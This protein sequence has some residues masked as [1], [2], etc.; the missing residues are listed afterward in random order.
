MVRYETVRGLSAAA[1]TLRKKPAPGHSS[2][3]ARL[4]KGAD[5]AA[6]LTEQSGRL[7]TA[8][9]TLRREIAKNRAV[10]GNDTK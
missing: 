5:H 4:A 6:Q 8:E 7:Q 1:A 9:E 10:D 3:T 2:L